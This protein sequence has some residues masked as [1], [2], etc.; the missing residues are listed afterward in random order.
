MREL[1]E[2]Q[3][4]EIASRHYAPEARH[5]G[6]NDFVAIHAAANEMTSL[7]EELGL[8]KESIRTIHRVAIEE[9]DE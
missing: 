7:R 1:P 3:L 8:I 9:M 4:R 6:I 5:I 2:D